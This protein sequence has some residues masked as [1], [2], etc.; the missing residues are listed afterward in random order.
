MPER[1]QQIERLYHLVLEREASQRAY[2]L[3]EACQGDESLRQE[4]ESLLAYQE[5]ASQFMESPG[6]AVVAQAVAQDRADSMIGRQLGA[7]EILSLLGAGGMGEVYRAHDNKLG[8]DVAIKI[9]PAEFA[10]DPERLARFRREARTLASLNHPNIAAI[11]GL[12]ESEGMDYSGPGTGGRGNTVRYPS[13]SDR[14]RPPTT[15]R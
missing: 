8:R 4:I 6:M 13:S 12:E 7:Y 5:Q 1:W 11:Y 3:D 10:Q 9:L 15:G 2:F 14:A